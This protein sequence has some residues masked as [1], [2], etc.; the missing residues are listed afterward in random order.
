MFQSVFNNALR[1][2]HGEELKKTVLCLRRGRPFRRGL[3]V[4]YVV[5][6]HCSVE[7]HESYSGRRAKLILHHDMCARS[8]EM[9]RS[10]EGPREYD[11]RINA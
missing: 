3:C 1:I 5:V 2:E 11:S 4:S 9:G 10:G 7:A 8:D 6:G